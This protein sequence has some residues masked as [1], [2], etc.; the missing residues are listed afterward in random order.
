MTTENTTT[1][2]PS[3]FSMKAVFTPKRLMIGAG[4]LVVTAGAVYA[5]PKAMRAIKASRANTKAMK[6]AK[7]VTDMAIS[8][9]AEAS[10][11]TLT[12]VA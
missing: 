5:G 3:K 9:A 10:K 8:A 2:A 11:E 12:A 1:T 4:V 6:G 7:D